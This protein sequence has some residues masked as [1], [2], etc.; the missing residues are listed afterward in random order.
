M[1]KAI[2]FIILIVV[3]LFS[4]TAISQSERPKNTDLNQSKSIAIQKPIKGF[5]MEDRD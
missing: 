3:V 4:F 2:Y 1:N 5:A